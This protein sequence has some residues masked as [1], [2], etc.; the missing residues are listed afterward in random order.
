MIDFKSAE[1][2]NKWLGE[3]KPAAIA[4]EEKGNTVCVCRSIHK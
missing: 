1:K 4:Y 2:Q 3:I